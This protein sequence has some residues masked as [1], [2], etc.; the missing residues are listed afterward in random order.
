MSII[1]GRAVIARNSAI[2]V[3]ASSLV[4]RVA[5]Y[6]TATVK[7]CGTF[8]VALYF[9]TIFNALVEEFLRISLI[10]FR[11]KSKRFFQFQLFRHLL[12]NF[13]PNFGSQ[14][15]VL[16]GCSPFP[17]VAEAVQEE[18]ESYKSQEDE[19]RRLKNAMVRTIDCQF[20]CEYETI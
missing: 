8:V 7:I 1:G 20:V 11:A 9:F 17:M 6:T 18:L 19:V 14:K 13:L 15:M 3:G 4:Y 12:Q 5:Q 10:R 16:W 2:F